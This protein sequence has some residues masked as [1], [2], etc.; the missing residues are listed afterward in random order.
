MHKP[1]HLIP[2]PDVGEGKRGEEGYLGYLLR[3]ANAAHRLRMERA[4]GEL[5]AT[6]PQFLVLTMLG[7]YPGLSNADLARLAMLTPQ[8]LSVIVANLER[9]G[10]ITRKAHAVHGRIQELSLSDAGKDLLARCR[11]RVQD[12]EQRLS[13][14]LSEADERIIRRWLVAVAVDRQA[15]KR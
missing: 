11:L 5:D 9:A 4:L 14:G 2:P 10:A 13:E 1:S 12:T 3:Q 7:A 6:L 8:T 15:G